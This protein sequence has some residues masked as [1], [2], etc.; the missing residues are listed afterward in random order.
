MKKDTETAGN[1]RPLRKI[2]LDT[3]YHNPQT[4][5][6]TAKLPGLFDAYKSSRLI[7]RHADETMEDFR[8][9]HQH[10]THE[11]ILR[12][13]RTGEGSRASERRPKILSSQATPSERLGERSTVSGE[14]SDNVDTVVEQTTYNMVTMEA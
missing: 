12:H 13:R 9:H 4:Q 8:K 3:P 2:T 6:P 5:G 7:A 10:L 14:E 1:S 11:Q